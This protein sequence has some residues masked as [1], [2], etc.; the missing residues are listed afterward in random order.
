[1][2]LDLSEDG[3]A[4]YLKDQVVQEGWMLGYED[5]TLPPSKRILRHFTSVYPPSTCSSNTHVNSTLLSS[6]VSIK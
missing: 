6:Y 4:L 3:N 5:D 2:F 1:M